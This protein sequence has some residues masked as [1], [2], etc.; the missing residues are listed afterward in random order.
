MEIKLQNVTKYYQDGDKSTK[1]IENV[2]LSFDTD[3]SFVVITGESG[4]GKSTLI[5]VLTGLEDFDEGEIT[6]DNVPLSGMSDK[7][8]HELYSR[9]ISFVFQ[10]YNL[11]ESFTA[12]ENIKLALVR[13]GED[14]KSAEKKALEVLEKVGLKDQ[15]NF[16]T[17]KLS[18][19][20]RQRVAI[21]RSLA[22][23]T[24]VI[25]FDEPTGNLDQNTSKEIIDLI[26]EVSK[27]RLIIYVTHE[28]YQVQ[29]VVTRHIV[30]KDGGVESD[31]IIRKMEPEK[32]SEPVSAKSRKYSFQGK[33][34]S[35]ILFAFRRPGRFLVTALVLLLTA[36][37]CFGASI[38]SGLA[39]GGLDY[40]A[41][42]R[43]VGSGIGNEVLVTKKDYSADPIKVSGDI[44]EDK[45]DVLKRTKFSLVESSLIKNPSGYSYETDHQYN[46]VFPQGQLLPYFNLSYKMGEGCL[47]EGKDSVYLIMSKYNYESETYYIKD[48]EDLIGAETY[49]NPGYLNSKDEITNLKSTFFDKI[50]PLTFSGV[51]YTDELNA[52][53]YYFYIPNTNTLSSF[54]DKYVSFFLTDASTYRESSGTLRIE[55]WQY[56]L[57]ISC[58][59][60]G[61]KLEFDTVTYLMEEDGVPG[62]YFDPY[63]KDKESEVTIRFNDFEFPLSDLKNKYYEGSHSPTGTYAVRIFSDYAMDQEVGDS[64][65]QRRYYF[66]DTKQ[67]SDFE[68]SIDSSSYLVS[69]L[70]KISTKYYSINQLESTS[71]STRISVLLAFV[72]L[73]FI[74][75]LVLTLIKRIL[76]NFYYRKG[77]DQMVLGYI[78]YSLK[79]TLII[80]LFQFLTL[81]VISNL[82]VYPIM[83][84]TNSFILQ[85]FTNY[86]AFFLFTA[87]VNLLFSVYLSMPI[88]K[89]RKK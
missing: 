22:L 69:V 89:R 65:Y 12:K 87:L 4:A 24:K 27:G 47:A 63:W 79:D 37:A 50:D 35:S 60:N 55:S 30:L 8:R 18:G 11:V 40:F 26:K 6:F 68:K 21:A 84:L 71:V 42:S 78:G 86:M 13:A 49:L 33:F 15:A 14:L 62:F 77:N 3:G 31:T 51:Y 59:D 53:Q 85:L 44:F 54:F 36:F 2:S 32:E 43:E 58:M 17:S 46:Y 72:A 64:G 5:R 38:I 39:Y 70:P 10:D 74:L 19:G 67:I 16:R 41:Q 20:E 88:R 28:Y 61:R 56:D 82:I 52:N 25:I 83:L 80:N 9:N 81:S 76:N 66:K 48:I 57:G 34:Y 1:G 45:Y 29:D 7:E 23:E 73:L 75:Y